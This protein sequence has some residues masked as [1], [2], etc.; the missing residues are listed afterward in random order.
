M[1][2]GHVTAPL[3][4]T[5]EPD[6]P[7]DSTYVPSG[8]INNSSAPARQ[9]VVLTPTNHATAGN[10]PTSGDL[11]AGEHTVTVTVH[12]LLLNALL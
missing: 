10:V 9:Q 5:I 4:E 7:N 3:L 11:E 8:R 2:G 1:S 12:W 6:E